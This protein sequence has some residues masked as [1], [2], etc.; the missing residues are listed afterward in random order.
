MS[1]RAPRKSFANP[2]VITLAAIPA[3]YATTG[4]TSQPAPVT[5]APQ[6]Q[7]PGET[8]VANPPRPEP[9]PTDPTPGGEVVVA[10]PPRPAPTQTYDY[11]QTWTVRRSGGEC[12]AYVEANCPKPVAG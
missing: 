9:A 12:L 10:N 11:D 5:Q 1:A 3:C 2:F 8:V 4:T 7:P 6:E